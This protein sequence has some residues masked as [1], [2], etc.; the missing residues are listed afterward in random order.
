LL[1]F[2]LTGSLVQRD[3]Q[4]TRK[5][6]PHARVLEQAKIKNPDVRTKEPFP[7]EPAC[8]QEESSSYR[9]FV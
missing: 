4:P 9:Y 1:R 2:F 6:E 5:P 3:S 7:W 8:A